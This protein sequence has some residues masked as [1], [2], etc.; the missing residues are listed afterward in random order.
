MSEFEGRH[1]TDYTRDELTLAAEWVR[2]LARTVKVVRLYRARNPVAVDTRG[3]LADSL[4]SHLARFGAWSFRITASEIW[5]GDEAIVKPEPREGREHAP[6]T[7][8]E[9]LPFLFFRD[10][11]RQMTFMP[12]ITPHDVDALVDALIEAWSDRGNIDDVVTFLWQ[13]NPTHIHLET[14]PF[15]QMLYVSTGP[16]EKFEEERGHALTH[17]AT[18]AT[19]EIR[20]DLGTEG[21]AGLQKDTGLEEEAPDW[22]ADVEESYNQ[23]KL[24]AAPGVAAMQ[25]AWDLEKNAERLPLAAKLF[26]RIVKS[27]HAPNARE[28]LARY[29]VTGVAGSIAHVHWD[30]ACR[31]LDVVRRLDADGAV[32]AGALIE[33]VAQES[34]MDLGDALD[35]ATPVEQARFFAFAVGLGE[36]GVSL[37]LAALAGSTKPRTRAAA[38]TALG[39]LCAD[40]PE[41]LGDAVGDHRPDV[42]SGVIS[43]LGQIGGVEVLPMLGLA[44]QHPN[45]RIRREVAKALPA[46]PAY[47]RANLVIRMIEVDDPLLN[48]EAL[49]VARLAPD[50]RIA[51]A[52]LKLAEQSAFDDRPEEI[53]TACYQ[54][55]AEAGGDS[56]VAA[57]EEQVTQGNW[58]ARPS[59]RRSAAAYALA[60][61][62]SEAARAALDRGLKH[63][64]ET[65]R[66]SC[67]DALERRAA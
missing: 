45:P 62:G 5:L 48:A 58:F 42:V 43:V 6:P 18:P 35:E 24:A 27:P 40:H 38:C 63:A 41:R 17:G 60:R 9:Q 12:G 57:L 4:A 32:T 14:V 49:K 28:I 52:I 54:A 61:I 8:L 7:L 13:A 31:T 53:K 65:V 59:W 10:G 11:V 23:I 64:S 22:S 46:V 16:G 15:E 33:A 21:P 55:L 67:R 44:A 19:E 2:D 25:R 29:V 56:V 20:A 26:D 50:P 51:R 34:E 3:R 37:A 66:A 39:Y 30:E 1:G 47:E 36:A